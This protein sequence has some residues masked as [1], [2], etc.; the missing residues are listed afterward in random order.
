MCRSKIEGASRAVLGAT[1]LAVLLGGCSD[2]FTDRRETLAFGGGDAI[3]ANVA[4][5]TIDPMPRYAYDQNIPYNG[6]RMQRA[7]ECYRAD[8]VNQPI[9]PDSAIAVGA[10]LPLPPGAACEGKMSNGSAA[11]ATGAAIGNSS[12]PA[13]AT[14]SK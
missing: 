1:A 5:Q 10:P 8:K 2:V 12:G 14:A 3:A 13:A 4:E 7:V 6:E 9:D 11:L